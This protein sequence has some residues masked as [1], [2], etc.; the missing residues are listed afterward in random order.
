L[1][2]K[3]QLFNEKSVFECFLLEPEGLQSV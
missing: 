1:A 3:T 2:E